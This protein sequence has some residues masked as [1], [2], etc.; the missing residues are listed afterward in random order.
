[1][2]TSQPATPLIQVRDLTRTFGTF[3]ATDAVTFDVP[4]GQ[5]FG[6]LGPK[7]SGKSTT[8][9][10]LAGV[11]AP[12]SG[13]VI[14]FDGL[15][16]VRDTERWKQRTGYMS[17]KFSLYLDLTVEENLQF[18]GSIYGLQAAPL[19]DRIHD[20]AAKLELEP[21]LYSLASV[22][23]TGQR[24]RVAL[25]AS[26]LHEPELLFLDEPT[27]G[28]DPRGR[29]MF[30]E[31]IDELAASRGMTVLV[32]THDMN[33]A[34][35]CDRLAFMLNGQLMAEGRP[36]ALHTPPI[37]RSKTCSSRWHDNK[38]RSRRPAHPQW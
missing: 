3:V 26:L 20:V 27:G 2:L 18:F 34:E 32:T 30:W 6:V 4:R 12:T 29:R 5:I 11:L 31:L 19:R 15:D 14:G 24:Q 13:R 17:Q 7:G 16:V 22:L 21:L 10:I 38:P 8:V 9:R 1:M 35:Q 37:L 33:E 23:S 36:S 28:L 25:A